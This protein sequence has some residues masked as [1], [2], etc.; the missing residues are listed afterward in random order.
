MFNDMLTFFVIFPGNETFEKLGSMGLLVNLVMYLSSVFNMK[1]IQATTL[2]SAFQG[3]TNLATIVGA[4]LSDTYFGRYK[5]IAFASIA[6]F[7]VLIFPC[8]LDSCS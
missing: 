3:T 2:M 1:N 8:L 6:S 4:F 5:T 7:M